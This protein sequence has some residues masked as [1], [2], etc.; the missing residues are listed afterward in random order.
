MG[1]A[2]DWAWCGGGA[3]SICFGKT[4]GE[5]YGAGRN[6]DG[7]LGLDNKTTYSSPVQ[8]ADKGWANAGHGSAYNRLHLM[9][10]NGGL[11]AMGG[12][13]GD[14]TSGTGD[15]AAHSSPIQVGTDTDWICIN[16]SGGGGRVTANVKLAIKKS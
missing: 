5:G 1:T 16:N 8:L 7:Y 6:D 2:T 13:G 12:S 11:W 3:T 10:S 9:A 14:G 4:N 15:T